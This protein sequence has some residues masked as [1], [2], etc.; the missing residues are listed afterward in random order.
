MISMESGTGALGQAYDEHLNS[1]Q[2]HIDKFNAAYQSLSQTVTDSALIK[3]LVDAGADI[4]TFIDKIVS[5]LDKIGGVAPIIM[6]LFGTIVGKNFG[7]ILNFTGLTTFSKGI[8]DIFTVLSSLGVKGGFF[9]N[10]S[11]GFKLL[12]ESAAASATGIGLAAGALTIIIAAIA[13][14]R[15]NDEAARQ[16]AVQASN[17][18]NSSM[19]SRQAS[20]EQYASKISE[21]KAKIDE[22]A[23]SQEEL[24]GV[25][26]ELLS[27]QGELRDVYGEEADSLNLL[28]ASADEAADAIKELNDGLTKKEASNYI[29]KYSDE[30]EKATQEIEQEK[31]YVDTV[32]GFTDS[33]GNALGDEGVYKQIQDIVSKYD[34]AELKL[35]NNSSNKAGG[36]IKLVIKANAKD[37]QETIYNLSQDIQDLRNNLAKDGIDLDDSFLFSGLTTGLNNVEDVLDDWESIYDNAQKAKIAQND[38]YSTIV[39]QYKEAE[40]AYE[41]ALKGTYDTA[42]ERSE[43][44]RKALE[45]MDI[46]KTLFNNTTFLDEDAGAQK[47]ISDLFDAFEEAAANEK[48]K[49]EFKWDI[50]SGE[51]RADILAGIYK[52]LKAFADESGEFSKVAIDLAGQEV[53]AANGVTD[54]LSKEA[55]AYIELNDVASQYGVTVSDM[56]TLLS[57]L[58]YLHFETADGIASEIA[59]L[60]S[61][62]DE[63]EHATEALTEYSAA[64]AGGEKGDIASQYASAYKKFIDDWNAGKTGTNAV[65]AAIEL[66]IPNEVL[67]GLDYDLSAAGEL[68]SSE[69][70]QRI[71]DDSGDYGAN[72]ARY[73]RE[74]YGDALDGIVDI[75]QNGDSFDIAISSYD[76]LAEALGM[77]VDLVVALCDALD[78]YGV[79]TMMSAEDTRGL[80]EGLGILSESMSNLDKVN[81]AIKGLAGEQYSATEIKQILDQLAAAQYIDLSGIQNIG[82]MIDE[83]MQDAEEAGDTEVEPKVTIDTSAFDDGMAHVDEELSKPRSTT[84]YVDIVTRYFTEDNTGGNDF[85]PS[86]KGVI[87]GALSNTGVKLNKGS[88]SGSKSTSGGKTANNI[89]N[90]KALG[91]AKGTLNARGGETLVNELGPEIISDNGEAYIAGG[92]EPTIVDLSPGAIVLDAETSK[93]ALKKKSFGGKRIR[94]AATGRSNYYAQI[95]CWK[96]GKQYSSAF[97]KCPSCKA[98]KDNPSSSSAYW[99]STRVCPVCGTRYSNSLSK[100]PTCAAKQSNSQSVSTANFGNNATVPMYGGGGSGGGGSGGG[101]GSSSSQKE[102]TWFEKQYAEHKHLV[103]MDKESQKAYLDWLTDAHKRAYDEGILDLKEYRKYQE[104]VYKGRQNDFKDSLGDMEHAIDLEKNGENNPQVIFNLYQQMLNNIKGELDK[105]Y[106][107]GL[108]SNNDYVQYLQNAWFKYND[109]M[110]DAREDA[111]SETEQQV[112]D[113]VDYRIKMLKQYIKNEIS[114]LKDRLSSLKDFYSKQKEMLQDVYDTENYLEEQ[115]EKRKNVADIQNELQQLE[116]DDSAWAQKRR[117]QLQQELEDAQKELNDFERQHALETAQDKLDSAYEIQEKAINSRID[118]LEKKEDDPKYLYDTALRDVQ[119][120]SMALYKE[121][122]DFNNAYGDGIEYT[123]V[124]MWEEAYV[125]LRKYA[126][127]YNEFYK[128]INLINATG[129]VPDESY[130]NLNISHTGYASGTKSATQGLHR[131]DELGAEYV[132]TSSNGN[133]YRLLSGGDKVLNSKATDFLYNFATNGGR[134]IPNMI[135]NSL[136]SITEARGKSGA[137]GEINMGDIIIQGNADERTVSEIRRAQR[138]SVDFMLK[139]F[140]RLKK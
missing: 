12:G 56:L 7:A 70:Y 57:E 87:T 112:K 129:Y 109:A 74:T 51:N 42:E 121:M 132:F 60:T 73:I 108:D 50:T 61:L 103:E 29:T 23:L 105:A 20:A 82:A 37:A 67:K 134:V 11:A 16:A 78:A 93:R 36:D 59:S 5:G 13:K 128:G 92:G 40:S 97:T 124:Q 102:E 44:I 117:L 100:C 106:A 54:G 18:F 24:Y 94:A 63:L 33:Q 69:L 22:G 131:I 111:A 114:T 26:S 39:K 116:F 81:A 91:A 52:P 2:A 14:K 15:Q 49:L 130:K 34:F 80:A 101:G 31:V 95:T 8:T 86:T 25:Q 43:A 99:S 133:R 32:I 136:S 48:L 41:E 64:M 10:I 19:A 126:E 119:N 115:S 104:E 77:D 107:N 3:W 66:F 113:L 137:V 17:D 21:L 135:A 122:I 30:I 27:I 6:T 53:E 65:Q 68:L 28:T 138:E 127:L 71:F 76:A 140:N 38:T 90:I 98:P 47:F 4:V 84:A 139:E 75:N 46:A 89:P 88:S 58:G 85:S 45:Q 9:K 72:F 83:A 125:S 35:D 110:K 118:E 96:C 55:L 123:I 120:N 79:Q 62:S 1:I